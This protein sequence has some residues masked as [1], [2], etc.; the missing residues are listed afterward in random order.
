MGPHPHFLI[1]FD[2]HRHALGA[3]RVDH[4]GFLPGPDG[5]GQQPFD[6]L[7]ADAPTPARQGR[8]INGQKVLEK[9]SPVRC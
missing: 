5:L 7:F 3:V 6:A 9:V 1:V 4:P 2:I 8:R